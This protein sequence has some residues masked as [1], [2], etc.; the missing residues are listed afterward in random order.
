MKKIL[1]LLLVL[2]VFLPAR[3]LSQFQLNGNAYA[4]G[5]E[6]FTLTDDVLWQGGSVWYLNQ[7]NINQA[8]DL[9]FRI[10]L[11]CRDET[12][13]DGMAFVLQQVSTSVGTGGGGLGYQGITPSLAVEFD[14]WQNTEV[15]DPSF[16]H[17]AIMRNGVTDHTISSNL[18]GPVTMLPGAPNVEDCQWHLVRVTWSP[19]TNQLQVYFDCQLRL[20]YTGNIRQTIFN[21]TSNVFWGFTGATGGSRNRHAFCLDYVSFTQFNQEVEICKGSSTQIDVGSGLSFQWTPTAGVS[22]PLQRNPILTPDT[23]TL[24]TVNVIDSCG[25]VRQNL[26]LV[27]VNELPEAIAG[28]DTTLCEGQ[29]AQLFA[30]GGVTYQWTPGSGLSATNIPNPVVLPTTPT[31]YTVTVTDSNGCRDTDVVQVNFMRA[32]AGPNFAICAGDSVRLTA[33]GGIAYAWSPA[34]G[35]SNTSISNPR[36]S[37]PVSTTYTV[38]VTDPSGCTDT[39]TVRI[40]V[41]P[42]PVANAGPDQSICMGDT[43]TLTGGTG[44]GYSWAPP[45]FLSSPNSAVTRAFP[46]QTTV[47]TL[48]VRDQFNC[49]RRDTMRLTVNALPVLAVAPDTASCEGIPVP[50]Q[51]F[52]DPGFQYQWEPAQWANNPNLAAPLVTP[53]SSRMFVVTLTDTNGCV[54]VDSQ[55]VRIMHANAGADVELCI[56]DSLRLQASG[57]IAYLWDPS[58]DLLFGNQPDPVV[59]PQIT[60]DFYVTVTDTIGCT[61]RDTVRVTVNPLPVTSVSSP[62]PYVCSEGTTQ[63]TATGGSQYIWT[64]G[65]LFNDST[66]AA[67]IATLYNFTQNVVD[68]TWLFVTVIDS[69][70]CVNYDS[71]GMEVRLLPIIAVSPDTFVCP[72]GS[73]P[74]WSTGGVGYAWSPG[75]TLSDTL[76]ANTIASPVRTTFYTTTITAVWGCSDSDSV[77]VYVIAPE[78]GRDTTICLLDST[79][80]L[81]G[82]GVSYLWSP[83]DGLSAVNVARPVASPAQTTRYVVVVT[84][85]LGCVDSDFVWVFVNPLPPANAGPDSSMCFGDSVQLGASGGVRYLWQPGAD[86]SSDTLSNPFAFPGVTTTYLVTVTDTNQCHRDD[87]LVLVVHP[88]PVTEAGP[89]TAICIG[90]TMN[91]R[92]SGAL[93]YVWS[94]A[95]GIAQVTNPVSPAS[96]PVTVLYT[97]TGTDQFGC[98]ESDSVR[99]R[100]K[101][102][103]ELAGDVT[104]SICVFQDAEL[105]VSGVGPGGE[106]TGYRWSTGDSTAIIRPAPRFTENYWVVSL[107]DGCPSDT[108]FGFVDVARDLPLPAF[109]ADPLEGFPP[110]EITFTNESEFASVYFWR[111]GDGE[112]SEVPSPVHTYLMPGEYEVELVADNGRGCPDSITFTFIKVW[113]A[114]LFFPN[115]FSPNGDGQND[116][117]YLPNGGWATLEVRIFDRWGKEVFFSEDPDFKWDGRVRGLDAPEGVFVFVVRAQDVKG[118]RFERSGSVTLLR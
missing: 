89:D 2:L 86:L 65:N 44:T 76:N 52:S 42:L 72:G 10:F 112:F 87:S 74:L 43:A 41:R 81:G 77:K 26:V 34:V 50:V 102:R 79:A 85:S 23:T 101:L 37:P 73:V 84:D 19:L 116:F 14:T 62:D 71:I 40:T 95:E 63:L 53:D 48:T 49:Q 93:T 98:V 27:T 38:T 106:P 25:N 28:P 46:S 100:V 61:N 36:V 83:P 24:Y 91:L 104:D 90:D 58:P 105:T 64:P 31:N 39:D 51:A 59:F 118:N 1:P 96:P 8:F 97:L 5:Q 117:F 54:R 99:I 66:L 68:S 35:V 29:S 16:D 60:T 57:G 78:A 113:E 12:G 3:S 108:L 32:E 75:A 11:G 92:G 67:P 70:G 18:A 69:N 6:C 111:F 114:S 4:T 17:M 21:N 15:G 94:P 115:A 22:N 88:L 9:Y 7:V 107:F 47:Y 110:L 30:S 13:A 109:T 103:P 20:T 56:F 82:G 55:F 45:F 33:S 80:L